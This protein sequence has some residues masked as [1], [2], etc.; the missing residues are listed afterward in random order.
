M[1]ADPIVDPTNAHPG[2][3]LTLNNVGIGVITALVYEY[4]AA[5]QVLGCTH[6]V[7]GADERTYRLG[8]IKH[9][10]GG[11]H[12]VAVTLLPRMGNNLSGIRA[13]KLVNDCPNI[14]D[15]IVCGIAGGVPNPRH[16]ATHVRLG[17]IVVS[18]P[19]GVLQYDLQ[20]KGLKRT[21]T[22]ATP[23]APSARIRNADLLLAADEVRG[24]RAWERHLDDGIAALGAK[25]ARLPADRDV[26][27]EPH[28]NL[29]R[30]LA[31]GVAQGAA[32]LI[33]K[34]LDYPAVAHP[35]DP[36]RREGKPR[37]FRGRIC[38]GNTLLKDYRAR[39]ELRELHNAL[40]V[41][42]EGSGVADAAHDSSRG[43][44][45]VRGTV[46]Y[47]NEH[48]NDDWHYHAA[49]AA[50]A[51]TRS[52]I[53]VITPQYVD[54]EVG[55]YVVSPKPLGG[56]TAPSTYSD[57]PQDE[58][59]GLRA[60]AD[61]LVHSE[62]QR[63]SH[64]TVGAP[65][66]PAVQTSQLS[67]SEA[68]KNMSP[69]SEATNGSQV[70]NIASAVSRTVSDLRADLTSHP[71]RHEGAAIESGKNA[72][73]ESTVADPVTHASQLSAEIDQQLMKWEFQR[74]FV[75]ATE[76]ENLLMAS[77]KSIPSKLLREIY[78]QLARVATVQARQNPNGTGS[79]DFSKARVLIGKV[80]NVQD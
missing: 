39:N 20:K 34:A 18:G 38:S 55:G 57:R 47:C 72:A 68:F 3:Q 21:H 63:S 23:S 12:I 1:A 74:A 70:L 69:L 59:E 73:A 77:E 71:A 51:Y 4:E 75:L 66:A 76:L 79:P 32:L 19:E 42:M 31:V 78:Y 44:F 15:L 24:E 49:L 80:K 37:V 8:L 13:T 56:T 30:R 25:W 26:L 52:L 58:V 65:N 29:V 48:K 40:A 17:D 16:C 33:G 27:R 22:R 2:L 9:R 36:D 53:E 43:H 67:S 54:H 60:V 35:R 62:Q 28:H 7:N 41:E 61:H 10:A 6:T 64:E 11:W 5:C 46:D 14:K 45:V 50:A